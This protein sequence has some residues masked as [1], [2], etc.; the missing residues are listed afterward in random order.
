MLVCS[1]IGKHGSKMAIGD[2]DDKMAPAMIRILPWRS[3]FVQLVFD[4]VFWLL[5]FVSVSH[6]KI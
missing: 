1:Q 2:V 5:E 3:S 6:R 4:S